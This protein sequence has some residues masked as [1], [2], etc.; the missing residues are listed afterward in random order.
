[1]TGDFRVITIAE[2]TPIKGKDRIV[3]SFAHGEIIVISKEENPIG[4][5]GLLF[6]CESTINVELLS[7]L[8]LF[9]EITLNKDPEKVGYFRDARV[10]PQI[11]AGVKCSGFFL[12]F[13]ELFGF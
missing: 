10:R 4:I 2:H 8:N 6:D 7:E 13:S 3:S 9:R 12:S 11:F 1:M 5:R